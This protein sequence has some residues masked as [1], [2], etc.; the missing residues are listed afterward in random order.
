M[1]R[2]RLLQSFRARFGGYQTVTASRGLGRNMSKRTPVLP[3][4]TPGNRARIRNGQ[5]ARKLRV[6]NA[7]YLI[8]SPW[9]SPSWDSMNVSLGGSSEAFLPGQFIGRLQVPES[10]SGRQQ[11][12]LEPIKADGRHVVARESKDAKWDVHRVVGTT[13]LLVLYPLGPIIPKEVVPEE[14]AL[15]R[16]TA[17]LNYLQS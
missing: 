9:N 7:L 16:S 5:D 4:Y 13:T 11:Q 14:D 15:L 2:G 12:V 10:L 8:V 1:L 6:A 17:Q 3:Q